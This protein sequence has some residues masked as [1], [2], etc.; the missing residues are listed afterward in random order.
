MTQIKNKKKKISSALNKMF[1]LV[2][3][4]AITVPVLVCVLAYNIRIR[5]QLKNKRTKKKIVQ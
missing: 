2:E 1:D 5:I 4:T 3:A